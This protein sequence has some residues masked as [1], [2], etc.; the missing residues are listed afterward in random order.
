MRRG[1]YLTTHSECETG[2]FLSCNGILFVLFRT[3][4]EH[5]DKIVSEFGIASSDKGISDLLYRREQS[6]GEAGSIPAY[7]YTYNNNSDRRR[8][9]DAWTFTDV[10]GELE[11]SYL[12]AVNKLTKTIQAITEQQQ[13][14]V[15]SSI[16]AYWTSKIK[17]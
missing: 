8:Q 15:A 4:A 11:K 7:F 13:R 12:A 17:K 2:M 5:S 1:E 9:S 3:R 16:R 6:L 14:L 10:Q